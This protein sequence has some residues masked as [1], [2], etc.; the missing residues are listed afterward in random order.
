MDKPLTPF[1]TEEYGL[2]YLWR[3]EPRK[4]KIQLAGE[5][6]TEEEMQVRSL[7]LFGA[8]AERREADAS[9]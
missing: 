4:N 6:K 1:F 2:L 3:P 7:H 9:V 5:F 8:Q